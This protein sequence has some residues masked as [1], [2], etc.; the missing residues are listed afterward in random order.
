MRR[1]LAIPLAAL[2]SGIV[3]GFGLAVSRMTDP[4]KIISFL[5]LAGSWDPSLLLVMA[6]ALIVATIGYRVA[7]GSA[8]LFDS[9]FHL[10]GNTRVDRRVIIGAAV[11]GIGWGLGGFC[12]GPAVAALGAAALNA[13]VFVAAMIAGGWLSRN[14]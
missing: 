14:W 3:F 8:P 1:E 13:V 6:S 2:G 5:N 10:P 7:I 4:N 9:K 12:P 11:F